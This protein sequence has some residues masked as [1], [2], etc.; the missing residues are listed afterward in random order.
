MMELS[1]MAQDRSEPDLSAPKSAIA[2]ISVVRW[3]RANAKR[4]W[5]RDI[6]RFL[7]LR[8]WVAGVWYSMVC[9]F[10]LVLMKLTR[11]VVNCIVGRWQT[12]ALSH[13]FLRLFVFYRLRSHITLDLHRR[14]DYI[15]SCSHRPMQADERIAASRGQV[16]TVSRRRGCGTR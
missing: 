1:A 14:C 2:L 13:S 6:V 3:A 5:E 12:F 9:Q 15:G 8:E 7:T 10:V 16:D 4:R 11:S